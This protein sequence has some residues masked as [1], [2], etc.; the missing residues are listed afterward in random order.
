[1][2]DYLEHLAS[3]ARLESGNAINIYISLVNL[4]NTYTAVRV[5]NYRLSLINS[6]IL[7]TSNSTDLN[8]YEKTKKWIY[9]VRKL[10]IL[11]SQSGELQRMQFFRKQREII[12]TL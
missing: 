5:H 11:I 9:A 2:I 6:F 3:T 1:M 8:V 12:E 4:D 10:S 7:T